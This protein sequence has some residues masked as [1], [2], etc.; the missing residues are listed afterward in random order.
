MR[1][2]E[3]ATAAIDASSSGRALVRRDVF[4]TGSRVR[5]QPIRFRSPNPAVHSRSLMASTSILMRI[6]YR[7]RKLLRIARNR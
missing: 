3:T 4:S 1:I 7:N 6:D 2:T 5:C